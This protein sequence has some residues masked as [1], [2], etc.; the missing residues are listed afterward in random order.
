MDD[1]IER[2][3]RRHPHVLDPISLQP[4]LVNPDGLAAAAE[5]RSLRAE[6]EAARETSAYAPVGDSDGDDGAGAR[7]T[8][9]FAGAALED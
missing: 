6:R 3:E 4:K 5:I 2:L 7:A 1:L 8:A 9:G